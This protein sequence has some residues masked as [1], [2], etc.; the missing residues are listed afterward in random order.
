MN[1]QE[2]QEILSKA[3]TFFKDNIVEN[4]ILSSWIKNLD[5][6]ILP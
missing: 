6:F 1:E 4:H 5:D 2:K 3:K